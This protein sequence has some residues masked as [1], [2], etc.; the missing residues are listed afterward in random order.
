MA[1]N[2][3]KRFRGRLIFA[4]LFGCGGVGFLQGFCEF[5]CANIVFWMVKRGELVVNIWSRDHT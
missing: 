1:S 3:L 4:R 2:P 5:W